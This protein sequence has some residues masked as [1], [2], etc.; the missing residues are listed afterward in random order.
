MKKF[1]V[2]TMIML[3]L[4]LVLGTMGNS[5]AT[6]SPDIT[7]E[8][9]PD[10]SGSATGS[11]T[12]VNPPGYYND[13]FSASISAQDSND[14]KFVF[15]HWDKW[16][17]I[18]PPGHNNSYW[19]WEF[20][21]SSPSKTFNIIFDTRVRAVF[22]EKFMYTYE[23]H[24]PENATYTGT[25]TG[26]YLPGASITGDAE[27]A[28][29]FRLSGWQ[30]NDG[31]MNGPEMLI[32]FNMPEDDTVL[33]LYFEEI[34]FYDV[35]TMVDPEGTGTT[36]GDGSYQVGDTV[37]LTATPIEHFSFDYWD[38]GE[39]ELI[40]TPGVNEG[41]I[42]FIMPEGNVDATAMFVEDP[43]VW[44]TPYYVDNANN[45]VQAPGDPIK[46]YLDEP[47]SISHP[48]SIGSYLFAYT[49]N[50]NDEGTLYSE[51]EPGDFDVFF[52]YYLPEVVTN[53]VTNTVTETIVV[54]VPA[55][56]EAPTE[57]IT[58][59][60]VPLGTASAP[61]NFDSIYDN[62]EMPTEEV[63][64]EEETPLADALPQ[65][66]QIPVELFYGVGG[67]LTAVGTYMKRKK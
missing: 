67:M 25:P 63:I 32:T 13:Y 48:A 31:P 54:T 44:A 30:V 37:E 65:T 57:A 7:V 52:H 43:Y 38:F 39:L 4:V 40:T 42:S 59:E 20:F 61:I 1:K 58:E 26:Y 46:V 49:L 15:D 33:H 60:V 51:D 56:T 64:A 3:T 27:F 21:S 6:Y 8:I 53:T 28:D 12:Y 18:D 62:M 22:K 50:D 5:F 14:G 35:T 17:Y 16:S 29:G 34:P 2:L 10:P 24:V 9:M 23:L 36:T 47:Y 55:T 45:D 66:G 41:D 19:G 11:V